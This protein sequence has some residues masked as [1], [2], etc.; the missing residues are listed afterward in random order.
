M[1]KLP[2]LLAVVLVIGL[3]AIFLWP[4]TEPPPPPP[5][6]VQETPVEEKKPEV[7]EPPPPMA[8]EPEVAVDPL[9]PLEESDNEVRQSAVDL[10]GQQPVETYLVPS[11]IARKIVV[12]V[13][14]DS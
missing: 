5:A 6:Q 11:G 3:A 13:R 8:A 7:F 10:A 4:R 1:S 14:G 2:W 9:P 12:T